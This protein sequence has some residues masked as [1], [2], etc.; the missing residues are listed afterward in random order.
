MCF[1]FKPLASEVQSLYNGAVKSASLPL[2]LA[3]SLSLLAPPLFAQPK[4]GDLILQAGF[5]GSNVLQTWSAEQNSHVRL[6]AGH[7]STHS[8]E[9][10]A[11]VAVTSNVLVRLA[12]PV[13]RLRGARLQCRAMVKADGVTQPPQPYNGIKF[14]LHLSGPGGD[15]WLQQNSVFGSF[16]WKSVRFNATVPDDV[17]SAELILGLEAVN[18]RASFDDLALTVLRGPRVRPATPPKGPPFTGH[19]EP[20]LR[21]A[22][23][24][25]DISAD[26]LRTLGQEWQANL[27]RWQLIRYGAAAKITDLAAYDQWLEGEL[28]KLDAALPLCEQYGLRV[29]LDLHSPPGGT[30]TASGYVGS[31]TGLFTNRAAQVKFVQLWQKV[32]LRYRDNKVIWGY[33]LANEPVEEEVGDGCDD[34]QALAT[35][36]ARA[37]RE[38]DPRRAIIIEPSPWGGPEALKN[39]DPIPVPGVVYSVHVYVPHQFTHQSIHGNPSGVRYPGTIAGQAWDKA[40]LRQALQ[41][42]LD[43]Q[44]DFGGHFYIGEFSAIRWAPDDSAARYLQDC[45]ELFE[46]HGWDWSYHAFREWDGWSVEHGSD[47][48]KHERSATPTSREQ[49]LRTWFGKNVK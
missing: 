10:T 29:V 28:R 33:D 6:A 37:V 39:L 34:W 43:F 11:P 42:V 3:A 38:I 49:L 9:L 46:E 15:A 5:E 20:R 31:D 12:L 2:A 22:M 44:R 7:H 8:L 23:I 24:H 32:A 1:R 45:V 26:S 25:P 41:P 18:G 21:G 27:I 47:P 35:R 30:P 16:D 14:M 17:T 19:D 40:R 4:A 13:A 36:T 48:Q